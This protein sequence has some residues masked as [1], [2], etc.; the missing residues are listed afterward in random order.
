LP[1]NIRPAHI[2]ATTAGALEERNLVDARHEL[3]SDNDAE[4][5]RTDER[6]GL[7]ILA[8]HVFTAVAVLMQHYSTLW[9]KAGVLPR[10]RL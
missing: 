5:R 8:R 4:P 6:I 2:G 3:G 1:Y 10:L 7:L 9:L